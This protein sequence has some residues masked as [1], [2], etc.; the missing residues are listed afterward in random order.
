MLK[1]DSS[2]INPIKAYK[3]KWSKCQL[4]PL[5]AKATNHVLYGG[6]IPA[7]ILF[8]GEAPGYTEDM[9]GEP[10]IDKAGKIF[11]LLVSE[12]GLSDSDY[13]VTNILACFPAKPDDPTNFRIPSKEEAKACHP[14]LLELIELVKPKLYVALGD[15]AKRYGLQDSTD[16]KIVHLRHP[17]FILRNGGYGSVEY[18]RNLYKLKESINGITKKSRL[19]K[20]IQ[21]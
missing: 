17:S 5:G 4:C 15:V 13:C 18:K 12:S 16:I 1:R 9:V 21:R 6:T 10:F 2:K 20:T 3:Q 11:D 8:V 7:S 14:R 19:K